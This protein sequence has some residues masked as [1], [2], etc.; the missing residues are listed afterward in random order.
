MAFL[1]QQLHCNKKSSCSVS[2]GAAVLV[3]GQLTLELI[4]FLITQPYR[5]N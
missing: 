1:S 5:S 4:T 2:G 3:L